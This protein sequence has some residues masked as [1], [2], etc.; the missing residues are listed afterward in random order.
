M[1]FGVVRACFL[2]KGGK[3]FVF[4]QHVMRTY[5]KVPSESELADADFHLMMMLCLS[6][7]CAYVR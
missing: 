4:V 7:N 3:R 6:C 1:L 5:C 2:T